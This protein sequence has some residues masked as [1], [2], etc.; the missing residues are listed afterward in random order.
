MTE[1]LTVYTDFVCPWCY[2]GD[3]YLQR[4]VAQSPVTITYVMYPLHPETPLNGISL[5]EIFAGRG[6]DV[7]A[8]QRAIREKAISMGL[9]YGKRTHTFNSR[10]AQVVGKAM[11]QHGL[12]DSYKRAVF[13]SYFG[14]GENISSN[15]VLQSII[16]QVQTIELKVADLIENPDYQKLVDLDWELCSQNNITGVPTYQYDNRYC[17]GAQNSASLLELFNP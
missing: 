3:T 15:D 10:N 6:I 17:V 13:R 14:K 12:F 16:D 4:A 9:E 8:S 7:D 5:K 2:I 11:A 1:T